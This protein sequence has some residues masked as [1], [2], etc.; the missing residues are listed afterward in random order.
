MNEIYLTSHSITYAQKMQKVL[1]LNG[2]NARIIR[3]D[4]RLSESG[5]AYA[6]S[7]SE[8]MSAETIEVLKNYR[9]MP[10]KFILR[11]NGGV[12]RELRV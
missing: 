10:V 6:V 7:V 1:Q 8:K 3:P 9:L 5:C 4:L 12:L 2:I 11:E